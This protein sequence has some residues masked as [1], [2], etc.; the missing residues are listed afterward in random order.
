MDYYCPAAKLVVELDGMTHV[1]QGEADDRRTAFLERQGVR[2]IRFTND[3]LLSAYEAVA[4]AIAR[5][6]GL[7]W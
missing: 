1:G 4:V 2:V 6:A 7:D 3:E 5:A